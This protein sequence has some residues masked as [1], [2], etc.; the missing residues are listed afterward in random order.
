MHLHM[1]MLPLFTRAAAVHSRSSRSHALHAS[2]PK[3]EPYVD[4]YGTGNADSRHELDQEVQTAAL[5]SSQAQKADES[6]PARVGLMRGLVGLAERVGHE[7]D[8]GLG[9]WRGVM[10]AG[11][12]HGRTFG[13]ARSR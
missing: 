6:C 4:P 7:R 9:R 3:S 1:T 8:G 10:V 5:M 11:R 2:K 12:R 13:Q